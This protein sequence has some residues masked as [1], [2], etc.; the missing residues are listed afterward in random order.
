[1]ALILFTRFFWASPQK[2]G[3]PL[4]T[5]YSPEEYNAG[6]QNWAAVRD[7]R[8]LLYMANNQGLLEFDVFGDVFGGRTFLGDRLVF[9]GQAQIL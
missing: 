1:M 5:N 9:G 3:L 4:I 8:G 2:L 7:H 6:I